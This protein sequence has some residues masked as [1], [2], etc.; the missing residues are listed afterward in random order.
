MIKNAD[1][2]G[3]SKCV[4]VDDPPEDIITNEND[5]F[6]TQ[7]LN[8]AVFLSYI[9]DSKYY[10][11]YIRPLRAG[12]I[13]KIRIDEN[14]FFTK[15]NH[16]GKDYYGECFDLRLNK[17][18]IINTF[19]ETN[20]PKEYFNKITNQ[21]GK[22]KIFI[23][24]SVDIIN[25]INEKNIDFLNNFNNEVDI[26][27]KNNESIFLDKDGILIVKS[28]EGANEQLEKIFTEEEVFKRLGL[29]KSYVS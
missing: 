28:K 18:N 26:V 17:E 29:Y 16:L 6:K 8:Y 3:E 2:N 1:D 15:Y 21:V 25:A 19:S 27:D 23:G 4:I 12:K 22:I 14:K 5:I 24:L 11:K 7:L 10:N 9:I 20:N 13:R